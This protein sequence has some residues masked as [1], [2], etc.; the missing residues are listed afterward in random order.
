VPHP[1]LLAPVVLLKSVPVPTAVCSLAVLRKSVPAPTPV[2][3]LAEPL[4][5][6]DKK[7]NAE[8]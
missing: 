8:L 2:L 4:L 1:V 3:K 5:N 7:P 6:S